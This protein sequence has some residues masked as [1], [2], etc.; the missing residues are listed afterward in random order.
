MRLLTLLLLLPATLLAQPGGG[1]AS[2]ASRP[3]A[4]ARE[5]DF[6]VGRWEL[7]VTPRVST[8]AARIHGPPRLRGTWRAWRALDGW[9]IEDE[10][11]IVDESGNPRSL[12]HAIRFY[13]PAARRW[14]VATVDAY[15]QRLT[16]GS[17]ARRG[18]EMVATGQAIDP[19]G[20]SY[21]T[22]SR[23]GRV[24]PTSF[25]YQQD[26]SYD[27]GATWDEAR[28]VIEARRVGTSAPR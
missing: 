8:L 11:R 12:A 25:R 7:T 1:G 2:R 4:E 21:V 20:R 13:D 5:F 28:L 6:L 10:L 16:Q 24:T 15:R 9:G 3:P 18:G 19:D 23:I 17:A 22:R 26:R 14:T 27:N